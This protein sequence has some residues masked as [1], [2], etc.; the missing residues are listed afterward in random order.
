[1]NNIP[2]IG[3]KI[4]NH[5]IVRKTDINSQANVPSSSPDTEPSAAA[6]DTAEFAVQT[7][8]K[9]YS[10]EQ[11]KKDYKHILRREVFSKLKPF[12]EERQKI[13][14]LLLM[15]GL[16]LTVII[17]IG[18]F[19]VCMKMQDYRIIIVPGSVFAWIWHS[20]KKKLENKVKNNMMPVLM[21]AV[22]NFFWSLDATISHGEL[23]EA[24][25]IP[26]LKKA[27]F[28]SDD[29]FKGTYRNVEVLIS[30]QE[31]QIGSGKNRRTLYRG[32][33]IKIQMNK[34]FQGITLV[35]PKGEKKLEH[36]LE[37][38]KLEDVDFGKRF[39]V[40]SDNQIEARYLITT[41]FMERFQNIRTAYNASKIY[42]AFYNRY[43]YIA[44]YCDKDLFSLAHLSKT[45]I[46]EEQYDILFKE[47]ASILALIDHFNLDKKLGL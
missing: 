2:R 36:K 21:N 17:T 30:E 35:R 15:I 25:I 45:L 18:L 4:V 8:Q 1:M 13:Y 12:E 14:K 29:N 33:I 19:I 37:E 41:S 20:Q 5:E 28:S 9:E 32:A 43:I 16:P 22:P 3:D 44:P 11:F 6:N 31:Y 47:F 24:D 46:D 38:V 42:G 26:Y 10:L 27:D 34:E 7:E 23:V 39:Q 40:F